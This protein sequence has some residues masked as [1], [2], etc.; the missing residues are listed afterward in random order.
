MKNMFATRTTAESEVGNQLKMGKFTILKD[1]LVGQGAF[2][3]VY[4]TKDESNR[5]Y[6]AK[7]LSKHS[8]DIST[9]AK[10]EVKIL[11]EINHPHIPKYVDSF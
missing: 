10:M 3:S 4:L 5:L 11:S 1:K 6:V 8:K 9:I 2:S 7:V